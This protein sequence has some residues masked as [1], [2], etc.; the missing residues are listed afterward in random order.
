MKVYRRSVSKKVVLIHARKWMVEIQARR[1]F[2][3]KFTSTRFKL[4]FCCTFP[5]QYQH[6]HHHHACALFLQSFIWP[7]IT[8]IQAEILILSMFL[9]AQYHTC[10]NT[11]I[12]SSFLHQSCPLSSSDDG[13]KKSPHG[14]IIF[15]KEVEI[16]RKTSFH[17]YHSSSFST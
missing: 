17:T 6:H 8:F 14:I 10:S 3:E 12:M 9:N 16:T 2:Y 11:F 15:H 13:S 5:Q 7:G 4:L 1:N